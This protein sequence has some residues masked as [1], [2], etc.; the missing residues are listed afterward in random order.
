VINPFT[1]TVKDSSLDL[2]KP[3]SCIHVALQ[4]ERRSHFTRR[5]VFNF[6]LYKFNQI[7]MTRS[8]SEESAGSHTDHD[9]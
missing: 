1:S 5:R 2:L 4:K 9:R 7:N 8:K 6:F 3:L